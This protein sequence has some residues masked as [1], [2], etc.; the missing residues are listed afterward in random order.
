MQAR[1]L[2]TQAIQA[3]ALGVST[4]RSLNQKSVKGASTPS[5]RAGWEELTQIALGVQVAGRGLL[6]IIMDFDSPDMID[7]EFAQMR[8]LVEVSGRPLSFSL[9]QN[10]G[11]PQGWRRLLDLVA[12]ARADGLVISAQVASARSWC[13][14]RLARQQQRV[15]GLRP[16]CRPPQ[17][18]RH[19]APGHCR[20]AL[21]QRP[22][23]RRAAP[24]A[25][26]ERLCHH[27]GARR[28]GLPRRPGQG[29][30]AGP[31]GAGPQETPIQS[32]SV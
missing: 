19:G 14:A 18:Y 25:V 30:A 11:N 2:T 9:M 20:T 29:R 12:Q 17:P 13:H 8:R 3:G 22:S 15:F 24:A 31:A 23:G 26:C 7:E 21:G 28:S 4:S 32:A 10:H 6:Q 27:L 16:A 1:A 5:L